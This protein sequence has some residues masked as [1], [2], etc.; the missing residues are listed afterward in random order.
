M[1]IIFLP[2]L[3]AN[4]PPNGEAIIWN[5]ANTATSMPKSLPFKSKSCKIVGNTGMTI[6]IPKNIKNILKYKTFNLLFILDL[7]L[8]Y[9]YKY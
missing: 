4:R 5:I 6:L 8:H 9:F 3:S 7:L 2:N 1:I